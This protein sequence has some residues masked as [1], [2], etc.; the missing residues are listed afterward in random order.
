MI[1]EKLKD[2]FWFVF[3]QNSRIDH[4]FRS[5]YHSLKSSTWIVNQKIKKSRFFFNSWFKNQNIFLSG[6][7]IYKSDSIKITFVYSLESESQELAFETLRS[8]I[9]QKN[10]HW[11]LIIFRQ[12][13]SIEIDWIN[14]NH[15]HTE[16]VE[17]INSESSSL[18]DF[19]SAVTTEF[20]VIAL[21]GD[22]YSPFFIN[23]FYLEL[24]KYPQSD[25]FF[26]DVLIYDNLIYPF[27]KPETYSPIFI[28]SA[29]YFSGTI[30]KC[31][32]IQKYLAENFNIIRSLIEQS[33][34]SKT[35]FINNDFIATHIPYIL[36]E[37]KI[38]PDHSIYR[39][40]EEKEII[41][42]SSAPKNEQVKIYSQPS[43]NSY[44]ASKLVSIIIPTKGNARTL[45][46]LIDS[47]VKYSQKHEFELIIVNNGNDLQML[48]KDSLRNTFQLTLKII[49]FLE[50]FNYSK[51]NN[52]GAA[53]ASGDYLL[54]LNDDM[55]IIQAD[56]LLR[57]TRD[58]QSKETAIAGAKLL[59]P[60]LTIQHAGIVIGMQGIGGHLYQHA[61]RHYF[62]LAGS[63]DWSRY[64][65]AVTGACQMM[66]TEVFRQLH[67]FD[68]A[69][70]LTFSD[71]DI[72]YRARMY[73]Y[74]ILYDPTV[75]II[76]HQGQSRGYYTPA[77]DIALARS[78]FAEELRDGDP[79][80]NHN[81]VAEPIPYCKEFRS[82]NF[83][84]N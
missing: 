64:V 50:T 38:K 56:W 2:L 36:S 83:E 27:F 16:N 20:C 22:K 44:T 52:L 37:H 72:C 40:A 57:L 11:K 78:R 7:P 10:P 26:N 23:I 9:E 34:H 15:F 70:R 17:I 77:D 53:N 75:E 66:P 42:S 18:K 67:G 32:I 47:I 63:A 1:K 58:V 35:Q 69:F 48:E 5:I 33:L 28:P 71:I 13:K 8:I 80:F 55:E 24:D 12:A 19:I 74:K 61:S 54:F 84:N 43:F 30:M 82:V 39:D 29:D 21:P 81:L 73:G 14:I 4:F 65:S 59:Y 62:G 46:R 6:L 76:H 51:A 68:E 3:P 31:S 49:P 60:N 41:E 79:F 45:T 25:L